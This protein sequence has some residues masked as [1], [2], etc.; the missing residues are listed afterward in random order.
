[1]EIHAANEIDAWKYI[2]F[3]NN[4]LKCTRMFAGWDPANLLIPGRP[5]AQG[6]PELLEPRE[7]PCG[8]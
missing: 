8:P 6:C 5:P 7:P 1:M 2:G 4:V 3:L